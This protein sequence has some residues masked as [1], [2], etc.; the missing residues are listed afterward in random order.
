M[1]RHMQRADTP[2]QQPTTGDEERSHRKFE[3]V[4]PRSLPRS[5]PDRMH[6]VPCWT[7]NVWHAKEE[8]ESDP[9]PRTGTRRSTRSNLRSVPPLASQNTSA[10]FRR[11]SSGRA[12]G[13]PCVRPC[14][15]SPD[16][17]TPRKTP[18]PDKRRHDPGDVPFRLAWIRIGQSKWN[19][20]QHPRPR[21]ISLPFQP[22]NTASL[23]RPTA[24]PALRPLPAPCARPFQPQ[25]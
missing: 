20:Q 22:P 16:R 8:F 23:C 10:H 5:R 11:R 25:P 7:R 13:R 6:R 9:T 12:R 17:R 19:H 21:L 1:P 15:S 3:Q 18:F 4:P 2:A 14:V 24:C